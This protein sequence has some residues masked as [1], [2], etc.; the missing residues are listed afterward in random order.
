MNEI[1]LDFES[2]EDRVPEQ[3]LLDA[4][5]ETSTADVSDEP[6][7]LVQWLTAQARATDSPTPEPAVIRPHQRR[8]AASGACVMVLAAVLLPLSQRGPG[9]ASPGLAAPATIEA[10]SETATPQP[11]SMLVSGNAAGCERSAGEV[12]VVGPVT[13]RGALRA[14]SGAHAIALFEAA[15]YRA[16]DGGKARQLLLAASA[17]VP[18]AATIQAGID[19]LPAG[20]TYC[21]HIAELAAGVYTVEIR[22]TPPGEPESVWRQQ[23]STS[24]GDGAVI[25]HITALPSG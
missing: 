3:I 21:A 18:D 7:E 13:G 9:E 19:S 23:I 22:E 24:H 4:H 10:A 25:T 6:V 14:H 11:S 5:E 1:D 2:D 20:T 17:T 16:R 15:Y 8:I 12:E